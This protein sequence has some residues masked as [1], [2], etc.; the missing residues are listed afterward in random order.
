MPVRPCEKRTSRPPR[1]LLR[2]PSTLTS[3]P[4]DAADDGAWYLTTLAS[5]SSLTW[6]VP[7]MAM[8]RTGNRKESSHRRGRRN[9]RCRRVS[10]RAMA[11]WAYPC[12]KFATLPS[13]KYPAGPGILLLL[14][15]VHVVDDNDDD[16]DDDVPSSSSSAGKYSRTG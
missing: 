11:T 3:P 16:D 2:L 14:V 13:T 8:Y 6:T 1:P 4:V 12:R 9:Q 10:L 5:S 7:G 15:V